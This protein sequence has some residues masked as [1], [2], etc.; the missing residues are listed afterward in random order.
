M[1][2]QWSVPNA[3]G[4][5]A[6]T[7]VRRSHWPFTLTIVGLVVLTC[8]AAV[9]SD[10]NLAVTIA[11]LAAALLLYVLIKLPIRYTALAM[12]FAS[13]VL[14]NPPENF[15]EDRWKSPIAPL[16]ALL[17]AQLKY[18]I[19]SGA[20]IFTG[21]DLLLLFLFSLYLFRRT[22]DSRVDVHDALPIPRP[23]LY[24]SWA[25]LGAVV[26]ALAWGLVTGGS[27]RWANWQIQRVVYLPIMFLFMQIAIPG[28]KFF[29][30]LGRLIML[31]ACIRAVL[32]IYV[33]H[34]FPQASYTTTHADSMLFATATCMLVITL[35]EKRDR[36]S[37][38]RFLLLFPLIL[39][40]MLANNR[41]LVWVE[42]VQTLVLILFVTRASRLKVK[43]ARIVLVA[44]PVFALY[45][46]VGWNSGSGIFR[47]V[48][49]VRSVVVSKTDSSSAWRDVENYDLMATLKSHPVLGTGYGHPFEMPVPIGLV[50]ELEPYVPHNSMLG[51]WA[52]TGYVGFSLLW[53]ILA[54]G[55]YYSLRAYRTATLANDRVIGLSCFSAIAVYM[56][57][58]YGDMALGTWVSLYLVPTALVVAGKLCVSLGSWP[59]PRRVRG[60]TG[61]EPGV[62]PP[63]S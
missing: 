60:T 28:P 37:F 1:T 39:W 62:V 12:M 58:L 45:C 50:Y 21:A 8:T 47:P 43:L 54:L 41:R 48:G 42:I 33:R 49:M 27:G 34:L 7:P 9:I 46:A 18:T 25:Y 61:A 57:H 29:P 19:P 20:L 44:V 2:E 5:V 55:I 52:Y 11:P 6:S 23:L 56:L 15:A 4:Q 32:A 35:L 13:L 31:A 38:R 51:M 40:G 53:M 24:A 10:G 30:L 59:M 14:E 26:L 16:G 17:L 22:V 63:R 36:G 3:V